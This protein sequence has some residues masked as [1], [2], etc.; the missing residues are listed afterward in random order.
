VIEAGEKMI[1]V[2]PNGTIIIGGPAAMARAQAD[3]EAVSEE[4]ELDYLAGV[5]PLY[6][7][8]AC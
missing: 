1:I 3:A 2:E 7:C 6:S 4:V 5:P 8:T